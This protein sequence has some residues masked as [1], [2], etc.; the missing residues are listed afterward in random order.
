MTKNAKTAKNTIQTVFD[1]SL[2]SHNAR[3]GPRQPGLEKKLK[4]NLL[5]ARYC[6]PKND[7]PPPRTA[8]TIS[9]PD[10][11]LVYLIWEFFLNRTLSGPPV[12][13]ESTFSTRPLHKTRRYTF[14]RPLPVVSGGLEKVLS[15]LT[16]GQ[17]LSLIHISEPTRPY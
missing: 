11:A 1:P 5:P 6:Y 12:N 15:V 16:G 7:I 8:Y 3:G 2:F 10:F 9:R 17:D 4:K 14:S 13:T